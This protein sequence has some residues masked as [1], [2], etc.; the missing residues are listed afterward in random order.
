[1]LLRYSFLCIQRRKVGDNF[2]GFSPSNADFH[3]YG[4]ESKEGRKEELKVEQKKLKG[5]E[6]GKVESWREKVERKG[7]RK[8][9]AQS[10]QPEIGNFP[11]FSL[12]TWSTELLACNRIF[13]LLSTASMLDL[14]LTL[15]HQDSQS[16]MRFLYW[17]KNSQHTKFTKSLHGPSTVNKW[18]GFHT[19]I[20]TDAAIAFDK[21]PCPLMVNSLFKMGTEREFPGGLLRIPG[22]HYWSL[23]LGT[24]DPT[25][26]TENS[27]PQHPKKGAKGLFHS[28][29]KA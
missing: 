24:W 11:C 10:C 28:I 3:V 2:C 16:C 15:E 14:P 17:C 27:P 6:K 4:K 21:I 1:M 25:G 9:K 26:C 23:G 22:F 8:R 13:S 7:E 19:I 18:W 5:R 20:S 29:T 12:G